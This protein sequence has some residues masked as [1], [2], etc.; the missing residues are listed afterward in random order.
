MW[1]SWRTTRHHLTVRSRLC[2]YDSGWLNSLITD[3]PQPSPIT[4]Q[5][6]KN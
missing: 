6:V 5:T 4:T 2:V 3:Q 1:M